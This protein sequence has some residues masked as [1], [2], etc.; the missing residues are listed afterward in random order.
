MRIVFLGQTGLAVSELALG[1]Q[2]FGWGAE[3]AEAYALA[4]RFV[5]EGGVFFD[6]SSTYNGGA[7]ESILGSW[8]KE[9]S[10][11]G[12]VVMATKVF[13]PT[14]SGPNDF[15]LS[16]R[17]IV[18]SAEE[19][20]RRLQTDFIDLYQAHCYDDSTPLEETL[21]AFDD[22]VRWGKVRYVGVSNFAPSQLV[23]ALCLA[24]ARA[25][26]APVSLQAEYSLLARSTEWE[27]LPVCEEQ[28]LALLAWSPLAGGWL[29]GKY[30]RG[31]PP[32]PGQQGSGER[33]AGTISR[34]RERASR[35]GE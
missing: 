19:S 13:F 16:R 31:H 33:T 12:S 8:I 10:C 30:R 24:G 5:E 3:K 27:L 2:T 4:D 21:R 15:G 11:R 34:I 22:L 25:W 26:S 32:D 29:S 17:H 23:R 7:S 14:G 28:G 6:T 35:H 9:R 18:Q 1:T 20:L